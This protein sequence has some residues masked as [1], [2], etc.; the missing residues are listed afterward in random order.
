MTPIRPF[1]LQPGDTI[2]I[3]S[4]SSPIAAYCPRR[5]ARGVKQL[6]ERGFKVLLGTHV[7]ARRAHT[8]GTIT[9]RLDDFHAMVGDPSVKAIVTSIGGFNSNQLLDGLDYGLIRHNPK[10]IMGYSDITFLL[11]AIHKMTG[12]V[13]FQGPQLLVQ[14]AE[15]GGFSGYSWDWFERILV[16]GLGPVELT[17]SLTMISEKLWWDKEDD[18]PRQVDP[19]SGPKVVRPGK[20]SGRLVAGNLGTMMSLAG[21]PFFPDL[22]GAILCIED[23]E[24][25]TPASIDRSLTQLRLMG[26]FDKIAAMVVGRFEPKVGYSK[27]DSFEEAVLQATRGH[28]FPLGMDFDFGHTDPLFILP[29]GIRAEVDFGDR[30]RLSLL[31]PAVQ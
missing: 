16:K 13:T 25:D 21:T 6:E 2:G 3:V 26:V 23:C 22:Q 1:R 29:N 17:P 15:H 14:M 30:A 5:L 18:R 27:D 31:E 19:H 12:L 4:P 8:A 10:I 11:L 20:T 24:P 9:Q 7:S 28:D